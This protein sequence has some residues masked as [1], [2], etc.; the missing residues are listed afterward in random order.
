MCR[1]LNVAAVRPCDYAPVARGVLAQASAAS[2][3]LLVALVSVRVTSPASRPSQLNPTARMRQVL[4]ER[5][6]T[7]RA[8]LA[9]RSGYDISH[10]MVL[11][12]EKS[13]APGA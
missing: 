7:L 11:H 5:C 2:L 12:P 13:N 4:S 3:A 9:M 10:P 8:V 1:L 6:V